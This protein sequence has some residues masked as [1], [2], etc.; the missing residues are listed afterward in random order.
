MKTTPLWYNRSNKRIRRASEQRLVNFMNVIS[1]QNVI[2]RYK[3]LDENGRQRE[4]PPAVDDVSFDVEE[5]EFIALVGHNGSGK[6]TLAKLFNGLLRPKSGKVFVLGQDTTDDALLFEIRKNVGVVFQNPDNQMV[7]TMVEDDVVFGPENI[8]LPPEEIGK[9]LEFALKAVGME[10]YRN[11]AGHRLSGGQKQRIAIAGVLA[12]MPKILVLDESTAMLDPQGRRE[13]M[14][15]IK[16]LNAELKMTVILITHFM[17]E[18]AQADRI[19]VMND[20]K[21]V[22][23]GTPGEIFAR[24]E[25]LDR[26]GL[27]VPLPTAVGAL[28]RERGLDLPGEILN[29]DELVEA[30]C[31]LKSEI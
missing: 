11:T 2:Y 12:V 10:A 25:E 4:L 31:R 3:Q 16:K 29:E 28:L 20:G 15:V 13:V 1:L 19:L 9:R 27:D 30:L 26:I 17:E 24:R 14:T 22:L 23:T 6:S 8:G 21:L 7:A 5:G 18:A